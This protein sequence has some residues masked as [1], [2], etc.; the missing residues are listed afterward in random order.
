MNLC[1]ACRDVHVGAAGGLA[2]ATR[3]LAG[4]LACQGHE[5]HLL[6]DM[7]PGPLPALDGVSVRR[8]L[9]PATSAPLDAA[10]PET[11]AHDLLHATAVHREVRRIHE[12]ERP[13][14]AV[15]APLWRSEGAVCVLDHEI[16]TIVSC[17]TRCAR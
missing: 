1:L 12:H 8:L 9:L 14:H 15:L 16:P 7:S 10:R 13:V 2:R 17:M 11:A 4:A 6:T 5:V 3:D